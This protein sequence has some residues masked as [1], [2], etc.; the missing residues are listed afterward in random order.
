MLSSSKKKL[1]KEKFCGAK[2]PM[3]TWDA[4]VDNII[5]SKLVEKKNLSKYLTR[6]LDEVI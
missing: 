6:Y 3:K 2:Q 1:A 4:N 5:I